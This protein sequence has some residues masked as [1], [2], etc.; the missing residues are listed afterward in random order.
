MPIVMVCVRGRLIQSKLQR[1]R[2]QILTE[3]RRLIAWFG[4][5][6]SP[7]GVVQRREHLLS[8][9][10]GEA[11]CLLLVLHVFRLESNLSAR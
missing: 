1:E 8:I 6:D 5:D 3:H 10:Y 11:S 4:A 2:K 9:V 7:R